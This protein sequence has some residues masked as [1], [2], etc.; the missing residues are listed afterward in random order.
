MTVRADDLL[1]QSRL[2]RTMLEMCIREQWIV[3]IGP[4]DEASFT[5][6]D[7]ARAALIA[8]LMLDLNVNAEGVDVILS[9]VERM[10]ALRKAISDLADL[11]RKEQ[12]LIDL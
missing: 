6:A 8:D 1:A 2:S 7:V 11:A 12:V 9:L 3:P 4:M 5:D 10:H